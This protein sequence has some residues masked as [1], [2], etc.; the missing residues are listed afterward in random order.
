MGKTMF[1][2][3]PTPVYRYTQK[4]YCITILN[5]NFDISIYRYV[6]HITNTN[7]WL[8]HTSIYSNLSLSSLLRFVLLT[9]SPGVKGLILVPF[10]GNLLS[11][12]PDLVKRAVRDL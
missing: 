4:Q 10:E 5:E 11:V 8:Y 12:E 9:N 2:K 6:L 7:V 3:L 1:T